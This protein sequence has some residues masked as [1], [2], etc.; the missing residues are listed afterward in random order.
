[1]KIVYLSPVGVLGGAERSLLDLM[2]SVQE[3]DPAAR[4]HLIA[5]SN[6]PLIRQAQALGIAT[7]L[8]A[9]PTE[10]VRLGD[11]AWKR[12]SRFRTWL[13]LTSR[14]PQAALAARRYA[15]RLARMLAALEPDLIH[16]NGLKFHLLG[17]LAG[18]KSCP[19]VWHL[20]DFLSLHPLMKRALA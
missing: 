19:V 3:A 10:L 11:S 5:A 15:Q 17:Q 14:L 6:G 13:G 18:L 8:L 20:R 2:A 1:M 4:L 9:M 7:T 12:G 16:S